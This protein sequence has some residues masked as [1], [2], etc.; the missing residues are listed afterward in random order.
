LLA[1]YLSYSNFISLTFLAYFKQSKW[2]FK[3]GNLSEESEHKTD[4]TGD[5]VMDDMSNG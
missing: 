5:A 2:I 4:V 3:S 1:D